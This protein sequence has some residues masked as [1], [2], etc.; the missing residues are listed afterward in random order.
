MGHPVVMEFGSFYKLESLWPVTVLMVS[1]VYWIETVAWCMDARHESEHLDHLFLYS[2]SRRDPSDISLSWWGF[3]HSWQ[4]T[5]R[6]S[7][8]RRDIVALLSVKGRL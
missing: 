4:G 8:V 7:Y 3:C 6:L 1:V 2:V 5:Q